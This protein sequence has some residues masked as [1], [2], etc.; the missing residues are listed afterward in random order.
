MKHIELFAGCGGLTLGLESAGFDLIFAN[1]LSPMAGKTFAYNLLSEDLSSSQNPPK[2]V[3]WLSSNFSKQDIHARIMENPLTIGEAPKFQDVSMDDTELLDQLKGSLLI[4]DIARLN[5]FLAHEG[6]AQRIKEHLGNGDIDLLSGGPPC[7]S[8]SMAGLRDLSNDRNRLPWE[9]VKTVELLKPKIAVLENVSGILRAFRVK[10]KRYFAWFEVCK[11]FAEKGYLPVCFHVN[12]KQIGVPQN[13]PRFLLFAIREDIAK[14]MLSSLGPVFSELLIKA[15]RF[16]KAVR[17]QGPLLAFDE[18]LITYQDSAHDHPIFSEAPFNAFTSH[19]DGD[20]VTVR[21]A[22]GDLIAG[23]NDLPSPYV[24]LINDSFGFR[25]QSSS[26]PDNTSTPNSSSLVRA[27]FRLYQVL[28]DLKR[29][30][31]D[32]AKVIADSLKNPGIKYQSIHEELLQLQSTDWL[33]SLDGSVLKRAGIDEIGELVEALKTK[34]QTQRALSADE[35]APA[36]LTIPDD[37]CHFDEHCQRTLSVRELARIQSFP[38]WFTFKSKVTTGGTSRRFQVP[39]YTQVGNAVP[40][41]LGKTIGL[42]C[43][44]LLSSSGTN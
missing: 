12:A 26:K 25:L 9:F 41:L 4:G 19:K 39:Q 30:R 3:H 14:T 8:F 15:S 22:I 44:Q 18:N 7:Q 13:R 33:L 27:R 5:D 36:T 20:Y 42:I 43:H 35:P 10:D 28:R 38:D 16:V 29:K 40:P 2:K 6:I 17:E 24:Q 31:P 11:A 21:E 37:A 1:E 23:P 34:K 32:S